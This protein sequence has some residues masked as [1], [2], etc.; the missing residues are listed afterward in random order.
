MTR[1]SFPFEKIFSGSDY[2]PNISALKDMLPKKCKGAPIR[3]DDVD[4]WIA[5]STGESTPVERVSQGHDLF[6]CI[7]YVA[8][9][10]WGIA[11]K[12]ETWE[13]V[14][15]SHWS[16]QLLSGTSLFAQV[17]AWSN[18]Y[19]FSVWKLA[20]LDTSP[21]SRNSENTPIRNRAPGGADHPHLNASVQ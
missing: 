2:E 12:A 10:K 19:G 4:I 18:S 16:I 9:K 7:S 20:D 11:V 8:K 1:D 14:A 13:G 15:R 17:A 3:E 5:R 6:R 21:D